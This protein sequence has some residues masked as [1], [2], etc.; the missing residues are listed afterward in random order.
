M[1]AQ[2]VDAKVRFED[3]PGLVGCELGVSDWF[4]IDQPRI[5]AFA[6]V[7]EDRQWIHCDVDRAKAEM[8][9]TIAHGFLT[10]SMLS[11]M[12]SQILQIEGFSRG[13]NYGFDKVRFLTPVPAG[14]RVRL[15]EKLRSAERKAGAMLLTRECAVEIEGRTRPAMTAEWIGVYYP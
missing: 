7:T 2:T 6:E 11:V 10:L 13:I 15:R 14:A 12:T 1:L 4:T 5:D 9:G 8:G 3:L